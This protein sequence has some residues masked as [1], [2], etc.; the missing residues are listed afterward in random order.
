MPLKQFDLRAIWSVLPRPTHL[1][2]NSYPLDGA[3]NGTRLA[4]DAS[5]YRHLLVEQETDAKAY[6]ADG[7]L[8]ERS[9]ILTFNG[10]TSTYLDIAMTDESLSNEFDALICAVLKEGESQASRARS[11]HAALDDWRLLLRMTLSR[12]L[13]AE[14]RIGLFGELFVLENLARIDSTNCFDIWTGPLGQPHDFELPTRCIEVKTTGL[15]G[16]HVRIH[17][18]KQ[19]E[20]DRTSLDLIVLTVTESPSGETLG[21]I[22]NRLRDAFS[23]QRF[24]ALLARAGW[25]SSMDPGPRYSVESSLLVPVA[26]ETTRLTTSE[27][28]PGIHGVDYDVDIEMLRP[29]STSLSRPALEQYLRNAA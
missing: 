8:S 28:P 4:V 15:N 21:A 6:S 14:R 7:L 27:V 2:F 24:D 1:M 12:T 3:F 5:G 25:S 29:S 17:G 10:Q 9:R 13:T 18:L 26:A 16:S 11:V 20:I 22:G 23:D 19:L